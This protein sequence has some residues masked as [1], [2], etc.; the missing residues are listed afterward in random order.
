MNFLLLDSFSKEALDTINKFREKHQ[1]PPLKWSRGLAKDAEAWARECAQSNTL[2]SA[3]TDDGENIYGLSGRAEV[4]GHEPIDKWYDGS[5]NYSFDNPGFK[6]DAGN[7]TQLVWKSSREVGIGKAISSSGNAVV[8]A[9]FRPAGNVQGRYE[10][11]V[12]PAKGSNSPSS[13]TRVY[14]SRIEKHDSKPLSTEHPSGSREKSWNDKKDDLFKKFEDL[15]IRHKEKDKGG[16]TKETTTYERGPGGR[17]VI[18]KTVVTKAG[19]G[20]SPHSVHREIRT[21]YKHE[22]DNDSGWKGGAR[23]NYDND[24]FFK[25]DDIGSRS[26]R[27][28]EKKKEYSPQ[29][30]RT[31]VKTDRPSS[32]GGSAPKSS[33][34]I[35][36]SFKNQCVDNHNKYRAMHSA[37]PLKWSDELAREAQYYAEKLAQQRSMQHSSKCSRNDAGENLAMFSGRYDTA[38]D[39]ACE[40]WYEESKKYSFVRGGFQGGTGHFTQMVWKGSKELGMGRAK[41][42]DGRCTYVVARYQPAGNI[43]NYMSENVSPK[44]C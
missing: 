43:V 22:G 35:D 18:T 39:M 5:K 40:M 17:T 16:K 32:G 27:R 25:N 1:S 19:D 12:F 15:G 37:P 26:Y 41:T 4:K 38:G 21:T 30:S 3:D 8:V 2:S 36:R 7:F 24:D 10:Q 34:P 29:I 11:N 13:T 31:Q 28:E 33:T 23:R 9:R 42:S 20:G 44:R 14:S 6:R